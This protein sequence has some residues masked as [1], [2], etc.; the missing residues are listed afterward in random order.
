MRMAFCDRCGVQ[1]GERRTNEAG[2]R[3]VRVTWQPLA[4][5]MDLCG[6]CRIALSGTLDNFLD[7]LHS[8]P[9]GPP[10]TQE[11]TT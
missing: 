1:G 10:E 8:V 9:S 5:V 3:V 6:P 2:V 11:A 4:R 7:E